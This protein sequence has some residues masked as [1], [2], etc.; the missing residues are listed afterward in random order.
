[1]LVS[2][3]EKYA[4]II[5]GVA[6]EPSFN[7]KVV[8]LL[9]IKTLKLEGRK[10]KHRFNKRKCYHIILA[11]FNNLAVFLLLIVHPLFS[12]SCEKTK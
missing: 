4:I 3:D 7:L 12:N 2:P 1:M 5:P 6:K 10:I 11:Q 9:N 8:Y